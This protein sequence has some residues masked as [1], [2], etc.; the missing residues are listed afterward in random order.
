MMMFGA[1]VLAV[2][3]LA[4]A[5][6]AAGATTRVV[7]DDG[8]AG[9]DYAT[10]QDTGS[11]TRL[12]LLQAVAIVETFAC[13]DA[14][15]FSGEVAQLKGVQVTNIVGDASNFKDFCYDLGDAS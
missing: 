15:K 10:I 8:G 11:M 12:L 5:G 3:M 14:L 9:V 4:C 1:G 13:A 7:A 2:L 6:M